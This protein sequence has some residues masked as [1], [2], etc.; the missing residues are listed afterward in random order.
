[1]SRGLF[2]RG[3]MGER[4][5]VGGGV[6]LMSPHVKVAKGLK[7][8]KPPSRNMHLWQFFPES[9][10]FSPLPFSQHPF[11]TSIPVLQSLFSH[12]SP[13]VPPIPAHNQES[14]SRFIA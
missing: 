9:V 13:A 11:S 6:G 14:K 1:M 10:Q 5:G 8:L 2:V 7:G 4:G 12:L 3:R